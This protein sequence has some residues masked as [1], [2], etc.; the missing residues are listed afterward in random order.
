[1]LNIF[2][3]VWI[4]FFGQDINYEYKAEEKLHPTLVVMFIDYTREKTELFPPA[5]IL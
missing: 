5:G 1:M 3:Y 4:I 2:K